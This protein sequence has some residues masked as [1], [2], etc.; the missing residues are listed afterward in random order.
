MSARK[1]LWG[2]PLFSLR[3]RSEPP[4]RTK[5]KRKKKGIVSVQS[6]KSQA[7]SF[8]REHAQS[9]VFDLKHHQGPHCVHYIYGL[10]LT[11]WSYNLCLENSFAFNLNNKAEYS[12]KPSSDRSVPKL[13]SAQARPYL[14]PVGSIWH[15]RRKWVLSLTTLK[16]IRKYW[17]NESDNKINMCTKAISGY[18]YKHQSH[19]MI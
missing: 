9:L 1:S 11:A 13:A 10:R 8:S 5:R 14:I 7:L 12:S 19:Y 18:Q 6:D 17:M 15:T 3:I 2:F 4:S 16:F